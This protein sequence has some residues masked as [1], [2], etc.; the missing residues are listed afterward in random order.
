ML[1]PCSQLFLVFLLEMRA[2][3]R[4]TPAVK[5]AVGERERERECVCVCVCMTGFNYCGLNVDHKNSLR[6]TMQIAFFFKGH[7]LQTVNA[8]RGWAVQNLHLL[9]HMHL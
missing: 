9:R 2:T 8:P 5:C 3:K 1:S 4:R 7:S 6:V